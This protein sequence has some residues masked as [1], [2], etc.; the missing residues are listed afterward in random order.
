MTKSR[1]KE[2]NE[3]IVSTK[4]EQKAKPMID[5][6]PGWAKEEKCYKDAIVRDVNTKK[7]VEG[8]WPRPHRRRELYL[9]R[10]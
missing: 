10:M 3:S 5:F 4:T 8:G 2:N 6:M 1:F 7:R 9:D